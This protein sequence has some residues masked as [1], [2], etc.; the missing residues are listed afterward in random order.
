MSTPELLMNLL[1]APGPSGHESAPAKVWRD[2]C[3][4][5]ASEVGG[6]RVGSSYARVPG[7]AAGV[8]VGGSSGSTTRTGLRLVP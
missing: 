2:Y 7:T 1:R 8:S 6:D 4:S 5:F 3:A